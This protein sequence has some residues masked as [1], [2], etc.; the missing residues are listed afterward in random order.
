[1]LAEQRGVSTELV[2]LRTAVLE[3]TATLGRK[4]D[5]LN[6]KEDIMAGTVQDAIVKIQ[7]LRDVELGVKATVDLTVTKLQ[8]LRDLVAAGGGDTQP[9]L[10]A[11]DQLTTDFTNEKDRLAA[12]VVANTPAAP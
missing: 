4:L 11:L 10:D 6:V 5:T 12:A 7:G 2:K 1:M 9:I 8:E 3:Q